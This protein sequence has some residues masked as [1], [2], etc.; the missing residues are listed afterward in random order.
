MRWI[1][2]RNSVVRVLCLPKG[3]FVVT[4]KRREAAFKEG[5]RG[6]GAGKDGAVVDR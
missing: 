1:Q 5:N 4:K 2:S 3:Y 6:A